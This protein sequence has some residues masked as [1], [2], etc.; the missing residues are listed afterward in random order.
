MWSLVSPMRHSISRDE[1]VRDAV[2]SHIRSLMGAHL[3]DIAV[4]DQHA[5]KPWFAGKLEFSPRVVDFSSEG[6][7]LGGGRLDYVAGRPAAAIIYTRHAHVINLLSSSDPSVLD[8]LP[9]K[10]ADR[11]YQSISWTE[12]GMRFCA[13]SDLNADELMAFVQLVRSAGNAGK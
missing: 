8:S 9:Q 2:S 11:G 3:A 6:F 1:F 5:V 12:S 13:V 7:P 4:S 10:T